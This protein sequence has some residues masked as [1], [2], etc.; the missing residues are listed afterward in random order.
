MTGRVDTA[1]NTLTFVGTFLGQWGVGAILN[2]WPPTP[3]GYDPR[4]YFWAFGALC[5]IQAGGSPGSG[6]AARNS[7]NR[8]GI[9]I[10]DD[11]HACSSA[12]VP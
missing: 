10:G 2:Q 9:L 1:L 6:A 3:T 7:Q 11:F 5:L 8:T 12:E 4:G